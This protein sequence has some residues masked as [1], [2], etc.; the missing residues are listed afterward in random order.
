MTL[1]ANQIM[2]FDLVISRDLKQLTQRPVKPRS[3]RKFMSL[4]REG[5]N[6]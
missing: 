5:D 2:A 3:G 1:I 4:C 6:R